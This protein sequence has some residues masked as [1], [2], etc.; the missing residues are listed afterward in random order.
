MEI[1]PEV[2]EDSLAISSS[3]IRRALSDGDLK[4]AELMLGNTDFAD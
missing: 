2:M 3:R 4:L 1:I